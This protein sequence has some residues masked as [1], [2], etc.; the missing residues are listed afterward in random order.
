M[1]DTTRHQPLRLQGA[2]AHLTVV[3]MAASSSRA[4]PTRPAF[5]DAPDRSDWTDGA[6]RAFT[7]AELQREI[8]LFA[9]KFATLGLHPGDR[10]LIMMPNIV[11]GVASI[12]GAMLA[13]YVPCPL[14]V[15]SSDRQVASAAEKVRASAIVTVCRY[16]HLAPAQTACAAASR[17]YGIR[18]VAAYGDRPPPGAIPLSGWPD[19]DI[20]HETLAAPQPH[21]TALITF[22]AQGEGEAFERTHAQ[23]V[24]EALALSAASGLTSRGQLL[25]T[26]TPVSAA[27]VIA[28]LA[29]PLLSGAQV[30]LH[31]PFS[32]ETLRKQLAESPDAVLILPSTAEA[33]VRTLLADGV[34]DA[35]VINRDP[36]LERFAADR[37]RVVELLCL[38]EWATWS[39]LRPPERRR[40]RLPRVYAHPVAS[41]LPPA[42][43]LIRSEASPAGMLVVSGPGIA[44]PYGAGAPATSWESDWVTRGDGPQHFTILTD[45]PAEAKAAVD[46]TLAA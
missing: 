11:E 30:R 17:Y 21:Q 14:S 43:V 15:V 24:S 31:G 32:P 4:R 27:G 38:G 3:G 18:F 13:G 26:F 22:D 9:R 41:A 33:A 6:A 1:S 37:G 45:H 44:Q 19:D 28:T 8:D 39:L 25:G 46:S 12:L 20:S 2:W 23:L 40:C 16:A 42:E 10:I 29:A 7:A 36:A 34:R 35:I 5:A